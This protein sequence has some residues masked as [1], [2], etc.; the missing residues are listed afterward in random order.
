MLPLPERVGRPRRCKLLQQSAAKVCCVCVCVHNNEII[1]SMHPNTSAYTRNSCESNW[2]QQPQKQPQQAQQKNFATREK[3][4]K[5]EK[6]EKREKKNNNF[7]WKQLNNQR[8]TKWRNTE[9]WLQLANIASWSRWS[10]DTFATGE[11]NELR[12]CP[13]CCPLAC[14]SSRCCCAGRAV[15]AP[16]YTLIYSQRYW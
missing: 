14:S 3:R 9:Q 10:K 15:S 13:A 11:R 2:V 1:N 7:N 12:C 6:V 8:A 16:Y 5:G 4:E